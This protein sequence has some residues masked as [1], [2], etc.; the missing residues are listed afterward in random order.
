MPPS[1]EPP[2]RHMKQKPAA[3]RKSKPKFEVPVETGL[4]TAPVGWVYRAGDE[5]EAKPVAPAAPPPAAS[6]PPTHYQKPNPFLIA[7]MGLLALGI[8]AAGLVSL[9]A[10]NL[11]FVPMGMARRML[12]SD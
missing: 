2:H 8:G 4:A 11:V 9:A 12:N 6:A 7:S 10:L 3:R 5:P 1:N